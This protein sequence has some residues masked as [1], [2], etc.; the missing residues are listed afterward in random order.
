VFVSVET[1]ESRPTDRQPLSRQQ[2]LAGAV[3]FVDEHGL[4][5]LSMHKLGATLGVKAMSLY[6]HVANK[7]DLLDGIVQ[8]LWTEIPIEPGG[9]DWRGAIRH[10]GAA[11]RELVH[12]H[13]HAAPLLTGRST[14]QE[15]PVWI[16]HA[17]LVVMRAGGVPETC[18]VALLRTVF[19]YGIGY[20]LAELSLPQPDTG[21]DVDQVAGI[22]RM[23]ALLSPQAPDDLI[24]TAL[25]VCGDCDMTAQFDIG[26][27]LMICGLDAYLTGNAPTDKAAACR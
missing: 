13:P 1:R 17:L 8:L 15:R 10:L 18:A 27:D 9:E 26:L 7:D 2:V 11:L 4:D 22:R 5:A 21:S 20:G 14:F 24:R 12:R 16:C 25:L 19:T 6:K 23:S 3:R